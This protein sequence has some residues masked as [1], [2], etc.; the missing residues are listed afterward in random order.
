MDIFG[1]DITTMVYWH[2]FAFAG[3]FFVLEVLTMGFFFL[4]FGVSAIFVGL[5]ILIFPD[6]DWQIQFLVWAG[7]AVADA[8]AWRYIIKGRGPQHEETDLL[9]NR[10][11]ELYIGRV[12]NVAVAIENGFGKVSV[13]D[14]LWGVSC[15]TD[16]PVHSKA[17]VIAVKGTL[18]EVEPA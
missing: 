16:L 2:W 12:V 10:R 14:T 7:M 15:K 5:L 6:L 18:L 17:R 3:I 9:L 11:A 8:A 13:D 1:F 4:W